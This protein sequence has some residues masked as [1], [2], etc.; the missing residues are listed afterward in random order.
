MSHPSVDFFRQKRKRSRWLRFF[1]TLSKKRI[2][3]AA[4]RAIAYLLIGLA[5]VFVALLSLSWVFGRL[6]APNFPASTSSL[7][8]SEGAVYSTA[9]ALRNFLPGHDVRIERRFAYNLRLYVD[10]KPFEDI[11]YPDRKPMMA[12]IG[13]LWCNSIGN[14]W[15]ARV[16]VFDIRSGERLSTHVCAFTKLKEVFLRKAKRIFNYSFLRGSTEAAA[17]L[18]AKGLVNELLFGEI[19]CNTKESRDNY[20]HER[21]ADLLRQHHCPETRACQFRTIAH[22]SRLHAGTLVSDQA[23]NIAFGIAGGPRALAAS[24]AS[25]EQAGSGEGVCFARAKTCPVCDVLALR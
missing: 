14:Q 17:A 2:P 25:L 10:R 12:K 19:Y 5:T 22:E 16:S 18:T 7:V 13:Q 4:R 9:M 20:D 6:I 11:P 3:S 21:I 24:D 1:K 8:K 23:L 15:L